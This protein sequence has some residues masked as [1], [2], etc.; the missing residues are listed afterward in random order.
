MREAIIDAL[1]LI[2]RGI[3]QL[4]EAFPNR[5]FTID[6]RL[7]GDIGEVIAGLEYDIELDD[8]S[9]PDHDARTRDGR[10]VQIKATFKNSLTFRRCPDLYLG[11]KLYAD[12]RHEEVYNGPGRLILE[13]YGRRKGIGMELLSFPVRELRSMSTAVAASERVPKRESKSAAVPKEQAPISSGRRKG[14]GR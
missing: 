4:R 1:A 8:I 14:R 12:G 13:R 2:F 6:G 9:R 3:A 10:R 5:A 11:F 7:V